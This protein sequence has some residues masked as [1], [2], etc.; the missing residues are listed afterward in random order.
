MRRK[1][2][3]FCLFRQLENVHIRGTPRILGVYIRGVPRI[4]TFL[5]K[6][7]PQILHLTLRGV[8]VPPYKLNVTPAGI[9]TML[10]QTGPCSSSSVGDALCNSTPHELQKGSEGRGLE[11]TGRANW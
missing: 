5:R 6:F 7:L 8:E 1:F 4:W 10:V 3:P 11:E 2:W 9:E